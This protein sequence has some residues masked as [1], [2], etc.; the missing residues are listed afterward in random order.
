MQIFFTS[1]PPIHKCATFII[2]WLL[3][4]TENCRFHCRIFHVCIWQQLS[5][6][7]KCL[8]QRDIADMHLPAE[9]LKGTHVNQYVFYEFLKC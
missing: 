4:I 1:K 7:L 8:K 9:Y 5:T 6:S 2:Q 3:R